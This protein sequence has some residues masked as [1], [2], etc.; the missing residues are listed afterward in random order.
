MQLSLTRRSASG[1]TMNAQYTLGYSKGNTGGS[2]EATT[3]S[4]NARA[5]ERVRL[6]R[7]LQQLRRP[8]HL[9]PERCSVRAFPAA[10]AAATGGWTVGGIV[11]ARSGLPVPVLIGRND[12]VYVDGAGNV[13]NNA[14]ADRTAVINTP[15]GGVVAQHAPAGSSSPA[16][17]RSS[18]TAGCCS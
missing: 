11:N 16:S 3:A 7:R 5:L 4:N 2:N 6:R 10:G 8:P 13:W 1:L 14:A 17:I 15:G 18:R 12:I 9:Q